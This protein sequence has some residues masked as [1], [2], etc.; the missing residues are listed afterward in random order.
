MNPNHQSNPLLLANTT[1]SIENLSPKQL[2]GECIDLATNL[3]KELVTHYIQNNK[4]A[5]NP[6]GGVL[7]LNIGEN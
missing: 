7:M 1:F 4:N 3:Y 6:F 5:H 2:L